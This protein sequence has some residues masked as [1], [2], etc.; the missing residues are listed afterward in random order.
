MRYLHARDS[1]TSTGNTNEMM[2][3]VRLEANRRLRR[4]ILLQGF[5]TRSSQ[6]N[7]F[8]IT[9]IRPSTAEASKMFFNTKK[10]IPSPQ[11][12]QPPTLP[13]ECSES[14]KKDLKLENRV[15]ILL[16]V[17]LGDATEQD[18]PKISVQEPWKLGL[19]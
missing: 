17:W 2:R 19:L 18:R 16:V 4:V 8:L 1:L 13:E 15:S 3:K 7:I 6:F 12:K 11:I 10:K 5:A 14:S 9:I